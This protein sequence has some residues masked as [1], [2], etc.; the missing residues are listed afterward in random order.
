MIN[1]LVK[2]GRQ[3]K[4][5]RH[6]AV[7]DGLPLFLMLPGSNENLASSRSADR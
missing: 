5:R 7:G 4:F 1:I 3:L 6:A 2:M